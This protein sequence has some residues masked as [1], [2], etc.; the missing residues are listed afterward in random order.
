M[1]LILKHL[2]RLKMAK[3]SLAAKGAKIRIVVNN[4]YRMLFVEKKFA[5]FRISV[6]TSLA[7]KTTL[8]TKNFV[9]SMKC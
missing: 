8:K 6:M 2:T 9:V 4:P 7:T 5:A 3:R 1:Y